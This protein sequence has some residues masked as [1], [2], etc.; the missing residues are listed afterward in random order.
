MTKQD[1]I[2]ALSEELLCTA[3]EAKDAL[4]KRHER[5]E[6]AREFIE[7]NRKMK[8]GKIQGTYPDIELYPLWGEYLKKQNG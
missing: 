2:A 6:F 1:K 7:T 3:T 5:V 4:D 8:S